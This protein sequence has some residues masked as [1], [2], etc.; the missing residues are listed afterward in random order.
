MQATIQIG[1]AV[2]VTAVMALLAL[3]PAAAAAKR[4]MAA[5]PDAAPLA[6]GAGY[7]L[8][9]GSDVVRVLQRRLHQAGEHPG[10]VDGRFGPLTEAAV[11]RFQRGHGLLVDGVVGRATHTALR[12]AA[13]LVEPGTGYASPH[14]ASRVRAIQRA[15]R[16]AGEDP[17]PIDGRFGPLTEAA[18]TRFQR[19]HGVAVDGVVGPATARALARA[20]RAA[21]ERVLSPGRHGQPKSVGGSGRAT[22]LRTRSGSD[23][24]DSQDSMWRL[25]TFTLAALTA[26]AVGVVLTVTRSQPRTQRR[27]GDAVPLA[28]ATQLVPTSRK[29][30]EEDPPAIPVLGYASVP[31]GHDQ[32]R[33]LRVQLAA[34]T[35]ECRDRGLELIDVVR[36]REPDSGKGLDRPGLGYALQRIAH[37]DAGGLVV[38]ELSR[39]CRSA[40]DLGEVL[41]WFSRARARLVAANPPLDTGEESGR[42]AARALI[43]VSSWERER[44]RERT[45]KGLEAARREARR[46]GRSGVADNPELSERIARMRAE[47]MT[48]Q[49]IADRLNEEGVPTVRGGAKW[50]PSSVQGAVGYRR[51]Q[52]RPEPSWG[53]P[54]ESDNEEI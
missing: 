34:I 49:A 10:P 12:R 33:E 52:E 46:V 9:R 24:S 5:S 53:L 26:V 2:T 30:K 23:S 11:I 18:V 1:K 37:G 7:E 40:N 4:S 27:K 14:G 44:L 51:P 17:G 20:T 42:L 50:R 16:L 6:Y 48:L 21:R 38:A 43:D 31:R 47:G 41:E 15:L 8:P 45:R 19:R 29:R 13:K 35:G 32:Q 39:L 54:P 28:A 25:A 36:E 22:A 3:S